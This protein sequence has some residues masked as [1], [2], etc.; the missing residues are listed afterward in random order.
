MIDD[1]L[2]KIET[3][4]KGAHRL[5][6]IKRETLLK[7]TDDLRQELKTVSKTREEDATTLAL[8]TKLNIHQK[9]QE[10]QNPTVTEHIS[11]G[12]SSALTQFETSNPK[13]VRVINSISTSLSKLGI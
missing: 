1:I 9:L 8:L 11:K 12:L 7:L 3:I 2:H 6:D 13:L 4:L 10:T 5:P